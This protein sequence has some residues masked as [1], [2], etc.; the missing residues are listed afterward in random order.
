M[1]G[2]SRL[3]LPEA[4]EFI[5]HWRLRDW[6]RLLSFEVEGCQFGAYR[7]AVRSEK[8]LQRW[9]WI[10]GVGDRWWPI[11]GAVYFLTAIKRVRGMHVLGP[12]WKPRRATA[13][14]PATAARQNAHRTF[15]THR[16]PD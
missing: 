2:A 11:L 15:S 6:L 5:G 10:E 14:A 1:L 9:S 13:A 8:W 16:A 4:G 12:A 3:Y 7:P